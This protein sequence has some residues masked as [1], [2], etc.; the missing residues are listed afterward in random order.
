MTHSCFQR[1]QKEIVVEQLTFLNFLCQQC[2]CTLYP[3]VVKVTALL[4]K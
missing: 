3:A 4:L 1:K 2:N